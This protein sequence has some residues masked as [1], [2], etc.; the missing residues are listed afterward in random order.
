MKLFYAIEEL[1]HI[2]D[3]YLDSEI[4]NENDLLSLERKFK[5]ATEGKNEEY[6]QQYFEMQDLDFYYYEQ[7]YPQLIRKTVFLQIYFTLENY[8]KIL[9]DVAQ[10]SRSLTV[11]YKD[12]HGQGIRKAEGYL[13]KVCNITKPFNSSKWESI[14]AYNELRNVIAHNS[15]ILNKKLKVTLHGLIISNND[16]GDMIFHLEREFIPSCIDIVEEFLKQFRDI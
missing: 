16:K 7:I 8:M 11:S 3:F 4:R 5:K 12:L 6:K 13:T 15:S 10:E 9:C 1:S 14:K 2:K